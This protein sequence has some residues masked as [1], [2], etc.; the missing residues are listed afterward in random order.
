MTAHMRSAITQS[1]IYKWWVFWAVAVGTIMSAIDH[2][3]IVVALP[4]FS[5]RPSGKSAA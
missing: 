5:Y 2:G 1:A 4:R 3:S